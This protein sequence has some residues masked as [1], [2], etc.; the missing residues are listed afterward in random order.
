MN[1]QNGAFITQQAKV[2]LQEMSNSIPVPL[3]KVT[4]LVLS[5]HK[6]V[7]AEEK[8]PHSWDPGPFQCRAGQT[9]E[10]C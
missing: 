5:P 1:H 4:N 2:T 7:K 10:S 8:E 3:K 6:V 9:V